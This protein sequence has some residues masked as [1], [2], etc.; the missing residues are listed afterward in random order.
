M[1]RRRTI[2]HLLLLAVLLFGA[3]AVDARVGG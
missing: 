3:V 1:K 2:L